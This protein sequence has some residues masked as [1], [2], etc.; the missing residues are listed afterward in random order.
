MEEDFP[1]LPLAATY[2]GSTNILPVHPA[3]VPTTGAPVLIIREDGDMVLVCDISS[4]N[5]LSK[6]ERCLVRLCSLEIRRTSDYFKVLLDPEKFQEGRSLLQSHGLMEAQHGS[7]K[8]ALE[9]VCIDQLFHMK[10]ELPPLSTKANLKEALTLYFQ[11]LCLDQEEYP[12]DSGGVFMRLINSPVSLLASLIV[13]SDRFV[14]YPALRRAFRLAQPL[15]NGKAIAPSRILQRLWNF[16]SSDEER[17]RE[18]IFLALFFQEPKSFGR[19]T[20]LLILR[21]SINWMANK[22]SGHA[23]LE[24][25]LWWHFPEGIEEELQIRHDSILDTI[26]EVQNYF[27][28]A[29]GA[30]NPYQTLQSSSCGPVMQPTRQLQCR[31]VLANSRACDSFQ[32]GEMIHFLTSRSKTLFLESAIYT[33]SGIRTCE[34]ENEDL[35]GAEDFSQECQDT[36]GMLREDSGRQYLPNQAE[37][38]ANINSLISYLRQCPEYQLDSYHLGCGLR[39]RL[40]P[41]LDH[42]A[43]FIGP[44]SFIGLCLKH[45]RYVMG[46]HDSWGNSQFRDRVKFGKKY[47]I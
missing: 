37:A 28:A 40:T 39:R 5:P 30:V 27:L 45:N 23:G 10:L 41:L 17:V 43:K 20:Q 22:P 36:S 47:Q 3:T 26:N 11:I 21:G 29:Y 46:G 12:S 25:P 6:Y 9:A 31:R 19:L 16:E 4:H 7:K 18:A 1:P 14:S 24:K 15:D 8:A 42:I 38:T 34:D 35:N 44:Q 13:L 32:L 33:E 2:A